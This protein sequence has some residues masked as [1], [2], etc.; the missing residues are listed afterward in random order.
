MHYKRCFWVVA[1]HVWK[2]FTK[3][4]RVQGRRCRVKL[5]AL[6]VN[7]TQDFML[8]GGNS[9]GS[10]P[11]CVIILPVIN[12]PCSP[13]GEKGSLKGRVSGEWARE[14][15]VRHKYLHHQQ[16]RQVS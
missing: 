11:R 6:V 12:P 2:D 8:V 4:L 14:K 3:G 7:Y 5:F 1:P 13:Y 15:G 10:I 16:E 9:T